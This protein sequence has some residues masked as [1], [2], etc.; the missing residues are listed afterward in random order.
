MV[1]TALERALG[2]HFRRPCPIARLRQRSNVYG[3]SHTLEEL[4]LTLKD[5]T[6]LAL[7]LKDLSRQA[8]LASARGIKPA[9]LDEPL[10]EIKVYRTLLAEAHLGTAV[11]YGTMVDPSRGRYWLFLERVPGVGLSQVGDFGTWQQAA[12]WLA[13]LHTRV[14]PAAVNAAGL[15]RLLVLNRDY[16]RLWLRRA[17]AFAADAFGPGA[18]EL[19][20]GLDRLAVGYGRVVERLTTLPVTFVH[21]EFYA[22]NVLVPP[23]GPAQ[24]VC[25]VDWE[26]AALG[27]GLLDLAALTAGGWTED[28]QLAL[29][30]AYADELAALGAQLPTAAACLTDLDCCRL[31]LAVQWLGWSSAWSPPQE[32]RHDWLTEAL[33]L[34]ERLGL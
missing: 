3:S 28:Q 14:G 17:R 34:A 9:F 6:E 32:H 5:G 29:A 26:S 25:P 7:M 21:G 1:R 8:L 13:A 22:A 30:Q 12:R 4:D 18:D 2:N 24:W 19:R 27:P 31:H 11:C 10:R 20:R 23:V 16:Y 33:M 15:A